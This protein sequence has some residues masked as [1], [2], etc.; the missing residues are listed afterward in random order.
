MKQLGSI[1]L[2]GTE[3]S[4]KTVSW[5]QL[6]QLV[7]SIQTVP[8]GCTQ[9]AF[10][11]AAFISGST[12]WQENCQSIRATFFPSTDPKENRVNFPKRPSVFQGSF[13]QPDSYQQPQEH[14]LP[15]S[16]LSRRVFLLSSQPVH[17]KIQSDC[18]KL[19]HSLHPEQITVLGMGGGGMGSMTGQDWN[20]ANLKQSYS[21]CLH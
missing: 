12:W 8:P 4:N 6:Q 5:G 17:S 15:G 18:T 14:W 1:W 16:T 10:L 9:H 11:H 19:A 2:T 21:W 20:D 7:D 13:K 3:I